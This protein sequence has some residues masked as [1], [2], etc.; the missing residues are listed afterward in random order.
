[1]ME[2]FLNNLLKLNNY[3]S[4]LLFLACSIKTVSWRSSSRR[5]TAKT[6]CFQRFHNNNI[7]VVTVLFPLNRARRLGRDVVDHSVHTFY[8]VT[9]SS[10]HFVKYFPGETEVVGG[11]AV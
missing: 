11:H 2:G 4:D 8:F 7:F 5:L 10:A 1:M 3:L 9:D 6:Y